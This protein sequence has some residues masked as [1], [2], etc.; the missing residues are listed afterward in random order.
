MKEKL[1][2]RIENKAVQ[3]KMRILLNN[4]FSLTEDHMGEMASGNI[5][6]SYLQVFPTVNEGLILENINMNLD[7]AE[8]LLLLVEGNPGLHWKA[9]EI[10]EIFTERS[11]AK[12][13]WKF[14]PSDQRD[15]ILKIITISY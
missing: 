13:V 5:N 11:N 1:L 12:V 9:M 6:S 3:K 7:R 4:G 2:R 14:H 15:K 8:N 10:A